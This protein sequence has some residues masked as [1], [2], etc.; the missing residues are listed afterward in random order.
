MRGAADQFGDDVDLR[1]VDDALPVGGHAA[2]RNRVRTRF[3]ERL[4]GDL[5]D[6]DLYADAR[7]HEAAI[8]LE[9]V[10][11]AAAHRAAADH[12][13]IYLLHR[14]AKLAAKRSKGQFNFNHGL[15]LN[16]VLVFVLV[17]GKR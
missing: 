14:S 7:G 9:R 4:H 6:V 15:R 13:E 8:E 2:T 10:K 11:H 16:F 1:V 12:S 3:V 17:L 5:A